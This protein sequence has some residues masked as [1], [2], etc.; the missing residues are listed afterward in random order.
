MM[1]VVVMCKQA[2]KKAELQERLQRLEKELTDETEL[3]LHEIM[4]QWSSSRRK[5]EDTL[6]SIGEG[7]DAL[8]LLG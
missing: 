1:L 6:K 8:I 4:L 7:D 2:A 5:A 3:K